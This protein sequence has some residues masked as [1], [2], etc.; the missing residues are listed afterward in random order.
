M[1]ALMQDIRYALRQLAVRPG[2]AAVV[3]LTLALGFGV[4]TA[5]FS[6]VNAVLLRPLPYPA[7]DR[8]TVVWGARNGQS[9][10]LISVADFLDYRARNKTFEDLGLVR[11]QS[12]NLTGT[13]QPDRLVG[14]FVTASTL[15]MLGARTVMGR[16]FTAQETAQGT[17]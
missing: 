16:L 5:I 6:V 4:N 12:V 13:D 1:E 15:P 2:F 10:L 9:P 17:G 14:S 3:V 7:A 8:L 11:T